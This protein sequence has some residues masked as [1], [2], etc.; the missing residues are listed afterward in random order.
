MTADSWHRGRKDEPRA[1]GRAGPQAALRGRQT[2]QPSTRGGL[3]SAKTPTKPSPRRE[4]A[5]AICPAG[6]LLL[7][8]P[9]LPVSRASHGGGRLLRK[10]LQD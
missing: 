9:A 8:P 2:T 1:L 5:Q 6:S 3:P 7:V 4:A 10:R